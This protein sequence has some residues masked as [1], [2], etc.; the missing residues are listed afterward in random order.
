M[1]KTKIALRKVRFIELL[2][3]K[4]TAIRKIFL[5]KLKFCRKGNDIFSIFAK[6]I[7]KNYSDVTKLD[8][9]KI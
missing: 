8:K 1:P 3:R 7:D 5:I 9:R 2:S 6:T 4:K